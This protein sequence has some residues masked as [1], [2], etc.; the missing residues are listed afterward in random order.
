MTFVDTV[1]TTDFVV[2]RGDSLTI[3]LGPVKIGGV[4]TDLTVGGTKMWL[5]VKKSRD[6]A[7]NIAEAQLTEAAGIALNS[8]VTADKNLATAV[9]GEATFADPTEYAKRTTLYWDAVYELGTRHE[10]I[11]RGRIIVV[12]SVT[13][14]T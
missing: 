3:Q 9:I 12:P 8:P 10:R 13:R 7:D 14:A 6:D 1:K 11:A 2:D 4:A 5:T